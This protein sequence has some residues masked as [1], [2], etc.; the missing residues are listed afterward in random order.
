ME[1]ILFAA[2]KKRTTDDGSIEL[3]VDPARVRRVMSDHGHSG[4]RIQQWIDDILSALLKV[5]T[6]QH[7][8]DGH[9]IDHVEKT[10]MTRHNPLRP[11]Q[12][13]PLWTVR[14]GKPLIELLTHD[15]PLYYDPA[16]IARLQHGVSQAVAR[17]VLTH[18]RAPTGGWRLDELI[19]TVGAPGRLDHRRRDVLADAQG[20]TAAGIGVQDGRVTV[21][22]PPGAGAADVRS[23]P[24]HVRSGP[25]DVRTGP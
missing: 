14:L 19:Q 3:L 11:D 23:G 7:D 24:E 5:E 17:H 22:Q 20:L 15:L 6:T 13:R 25:V 16:P 18:S 2:E 21:I 12:S 10:K 8:I 4:G 9:L 1:T